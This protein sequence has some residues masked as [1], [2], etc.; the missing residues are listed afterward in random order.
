MKRLIYSSI[1]IIVIISSGIFS[2]IYCDNASKDL[3]KE[4]NLSIEYT[5]QNNIS[6]AEKQIKIV[7]DKWE[8]YRKNLLLFI[9]HNE[10]DNLTKTIST[11][12]EYLK[13]NELDNFRIEADK[14]INILDELNKAEMPTPR[15][16][17]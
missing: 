1:I 12:D 14:A 6:G 17:F 15:N 16:L 8:K 2:L 11:L 13:Y 9:R 5:N 3:T 4:L 10:L 7:N